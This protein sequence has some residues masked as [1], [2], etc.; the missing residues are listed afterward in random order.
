[1]NA[2]LRFVVSVTLPDGFFAG[3]DLFC[4]HSTLIVTKCS[5]AATMLCP[6]RIPGLSPSKPILKCRI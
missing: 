4:T 5:A 6:Q 2:K 3:C 1:M